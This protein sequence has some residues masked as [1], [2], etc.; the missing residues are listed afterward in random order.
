MMPLWGITLCFSS[1][2]RLPLLLRDVLWLSTI[3]DAVAFLCSP[4][5]LSIPLTPDINKAFSSTQPQL[6][7]NVLIL[8]PFSGSPGDG[9]HAV[10][11]PIDQQFVKHSNPPVWQPTTI[12]HSKS[13]SRLFF[14]VHTKLRQVVFTASSCLHAVSCSN[15]T[16]SSKIFFYVLK[17]DSAFNWAN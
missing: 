13:V 17:F 10:K 9:C 15:V 2:Q 16:G 5:R 4:T 8:G 11:I 6:S 3:Q 12:S 7:G 1:L 14:D